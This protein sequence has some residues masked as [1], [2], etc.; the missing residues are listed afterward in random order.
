M[1][2]VTTSS[3]IQEMPRAAIVAVFLGGA[4]LANVV[5]IDLLLPRWPLH[6]WALQW[7][8]IH[9]GGVVAYGGHKVLGPAITGR[10]PFLLPRVYAV[11][12]TYS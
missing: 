11:C 8:V 2:D 1:V 5:V 9:L 7:R 4:P 10:C 6:V 12:T 3:V